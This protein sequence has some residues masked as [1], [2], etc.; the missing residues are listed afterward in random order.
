MAKKATLLCRAALPI[1]L[2]ANLSPG[3]R[4]AEACFATLAATRNFTLGRATHAEPTPDGTSVLYLRSG[5]RDTRLGLY[6]YALGTHAE[7]ALAQPASAPEQLS[8]EEKARRER[9]RMTLSGITDFALSQDGRRVLAAQADRLFTIALADGTTRPVPGTGWIGPRLAPDGT[10]V[11]GVRGN[12]VH[13]VELGTG[14]D[15]AL[16]PGGESAILRGQAE[17]AAAEELGRFDGIWWSPD[18][19]RLVIEEADQRRVER[20]FIADPAN[21]AVP[22]TEFR[23]PRAGT[24]NAVLRLSIVPRAGGKPT[25]IAWDREAFPYLARVVWPKAGKL[26]LVVLNREQ[27]ELRV[28]AVDPATGA[29]TTLLRETD[30]AWINL[31]PDIEVKT[32]GNA[33]LPHWLPDGS[34]FLWAEEQPGPAGL[35]QLQLRGADGGLKRAVTPPGLDFVSLVDVDPSDGTLVATARPDRLTTAAYRLRLDGTRGPAPLTPAPGLH[36]LTAGTGQHALLVDRFSLA[37]GGAG[38]ALLD[39]NGHELARLPDLSEQPPALP[40]PVFSEAGPN[41][42][43]ALLIRPAHAEPGR[44]YPVLLSVYAGP[45]VKVV[46]RA[47]RD[48][49]E[50][51]CVADAGFIVASI[52]GRGTP[53]R[54]HDF[55]R[56]TKFD[57]IDAPLADQVEGLRALGAANPDM[58][59]TRVAAMGWSFGGYFSA[60]A[61]IRRPDVFR[62]GVAGAPVIDWTDYDTAYTERYLGLPAAHPEA[63]RVSNVLTYADQ[64]SRPLMILHGLTDDNV[65]FAN[66]SKLAEALLRAGK[67]YHLVLLP[68]THLLPDP[69]LR[70]RVGEARLR[71][72]KE[73]LR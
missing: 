51:Q 68:G 21:P 63:Y 59:M 23:Y 13:V 41:H 43:D 24:P 64:L 48:Y 53:G 26:S 6:A 50:D 20:H 32:A 5:P 56:A 61:T 45:G 12:A 34:G 18:S 52:D 39:R 16:T 2:L 22:P 57:L 1:L 4:A 19:A 10:A 73:A 58:D 54:A 49:V 62:A 55:E 40:A 60:M 7:R 14:A 33:I 36:Q 44:K 37:D 15:R 9:A 35:W 11:A 30:P 46:Q 31:A 42:L 71:F 72:L 28:L 29:T 65:Y 69:V 38:T 27:T 8:A 25:A 17:F 3:A 47:P 66:T 70:A 67:P